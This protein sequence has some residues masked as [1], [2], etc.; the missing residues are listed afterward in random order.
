MT[1]K[2]WASR[3]LFTW[4]KEDKVFAKPTYKGRNA[5]EAILNRIIHIN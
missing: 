2:D 1:G 3:H 4:V 5:S